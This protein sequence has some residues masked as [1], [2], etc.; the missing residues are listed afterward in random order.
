MQKPPITFRF[1]E[2]EYD[3]LE[4]SKQDDES[5]NQCAARLLRE[6]LGIKVS[7]GMTLDTVTL[8][9][10]VNTRVNSHVNAIKFWLESHLEEKIKSEVQKQISA[11]KASTPKRGRPP[12]LQNDQESV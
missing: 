10:Y 9:E 1:S 4:K 6:K 7:E 2:A 5:I 12:K 11:Q 3:L 8:D